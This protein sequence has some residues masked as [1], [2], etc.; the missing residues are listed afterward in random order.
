[1]DL[2]IEASQ[3]QQ[4]KVSGLTRPAVV[5]QEVSGRVGSWCSESGLLV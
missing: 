3:E 4:F 2:L 5:A 1:V